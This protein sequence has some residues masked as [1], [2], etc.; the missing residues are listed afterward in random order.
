MNGE[1]TVED[2]RRA[3]QTLRINNVPPAVV[4]TKKQAS[5]MNRH[6]RALFLSGRWKIGDKYWILKS[7][8]DII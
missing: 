3:I 2:V 6:D 7:S 4:K 8:L 5:A 1:L